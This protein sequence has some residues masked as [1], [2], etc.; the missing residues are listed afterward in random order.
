LFRRAVG[1][2]DSV[3]NVATPEMLTAGPTGSVGGACRLL[4]V[5]CPRVSCTVRGESVNI[6]LTAI[7]WSRLSTPADAETAFRA[8]A[9]RVLPLWTSY[10]LY[11]ALIWTRVV[12]W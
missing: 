10:R 12:S 2:P 11:L 3:P 6:L 5:T 7:V 1:E 8:P 9:P 4:K